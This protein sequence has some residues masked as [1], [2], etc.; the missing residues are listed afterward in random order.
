[1]ARPGRR[2]AIAARACRRLVLGGL[3]P[4]GVTMERLRL[5]AEASTLLAATLDVKQTLREVA[6]AIVPDFADWCTITVIDEDG[7]PRRVAA[8]HRDPA[9][10]PLMDEYLAGFEPAAHKTDV[11][12]SAVRDG[13]NLFAPQV[14]HE[15]LVASAQSADHL[16]IM[17]GLGCTSSIVVALV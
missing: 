17:E 3:A 7:V 15:M 5:L 10:A 16:R 1:R 12:L 9:K 8:V 11:M 6:R 14:T 2:A 13:R 4:E